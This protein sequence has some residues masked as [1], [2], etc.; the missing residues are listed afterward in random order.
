[1]STKAPQ[2]KRRPSHFVRRRRPGAARDSFTGPIRSQA[3]AEREAAAWISIG[4]SAERVEA[5]PE[6]WRDVRAWE[7]AKRRE[8]QG[9]RS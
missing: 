7:R 4:W 3:Q 5:T 1:M 2:A 9:Q 6:V 8:R